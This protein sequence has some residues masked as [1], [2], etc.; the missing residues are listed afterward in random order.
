MAA[1]FQFANLCGSVY[2]RGNVTF[3]PDGDSLISP[4]GNRV[5]VFNLASSTS[6]TLPFEH[7]KGAT[8]KL[9]HRR[10]IPAFVQPCR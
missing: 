8:A 1:N 9:A 3:T 4:V 7:V 10:C 2:S 5:T 6:T